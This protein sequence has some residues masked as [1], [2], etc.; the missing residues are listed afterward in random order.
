MTG[1]V[2]ATRN[3]YIR[4]RGLLRHAAVWTAAVALIAMTM[5][6]TSAGRADAQQSPPPIVD[7]HLHTLSA[8]DQG[9]PPMG[10]CPDGLMQQALDIL[11]RRN[12]AGVASGPLVGKYAAAATG[13]HHI[14]AWPMIDDRLNGAK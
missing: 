7:G 1:E 11:R 2:V 9:P 10:S 4:L 14:E 8:A 12:I 6:L 3:R 5:G 13:V